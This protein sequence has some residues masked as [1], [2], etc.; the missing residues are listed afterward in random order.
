MLIAFLFISSR[1]RRICYTVKVEV[2]LA[3]APPANAGGRSRAPVHAAKAQPIARNS[4][5]RDNMLG[6]R[7]TIEEGTFD[8]R[9]VAV[10]PRL[11]QLCAADHVQRV[12]VVLSQVLVV[13]DA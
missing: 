6:L 10:K 2:V 1:K 13:V 5:R 11:H 9:P 12:D 4:E 7:P 8:R 3:D